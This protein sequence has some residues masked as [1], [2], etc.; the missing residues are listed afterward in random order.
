M[1]PAAPVHRIGQKL[2]RAIGKNEPGTGPDGITRDFR[3]RM[4]AH[5]ARHR[6]AIGKSEPGNAERIGR[7]NHLLGMRGAFEEGEVAPRPDLEKSRRAHAKSP[8]M[9]QPGSVA[10]RS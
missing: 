10:P 4:H 5:H 2:R 1:S 3:C 8:C 7:R 9:N 6:V